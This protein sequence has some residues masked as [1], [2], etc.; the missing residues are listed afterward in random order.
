M[1]SE[2]G[3]TLL[4]FVVLMLVL[5]LIAAAATYTVIQ[6]IDNYELEIKDKEYSN[7]AIDNSSIA[8]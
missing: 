7:N 6:N 1:R 8:Q 4:K 2:K 3:L 5:L